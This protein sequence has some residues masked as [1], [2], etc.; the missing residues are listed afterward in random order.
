[1]SRQVV[2]R[3]AIYLYLESIIAMSV[4]YFLWFI[5]SKIA[6]LEV[7]GVSSTVISLTIIFTT[8]VDL[9]VSYGS[10]RFLGRSFS[11]GQIEDTKVLIRASLFLLCVAIVACSSAVLIFKH[12]IFPS[13]IGFDLILVS[14]LI[15]GVSSVYAM[16]RSVLIASLQTQSFPKISIISSICNISLTI[17]LVLL[18]AGAIGITLGY[19]SGFVLGTILLSCTLLGILKPSQKESKISLSLACRNI[20]GASIPSWVP[21][22]MSVVG[23]RLGTVVVFGTEGASQAGS[24]FIATSVFYAITAVMDAL[25]SVAFPI[26]SAMDDQRKRFVWRL[27]KMI[28]ITTLPISSAAILYSDEIMAIFGP[29][30][31]QASLPL[32][33]I[34][35]STVTYTFN[36]GITIL[37]Y[38]YGNY[39]QVLAIGISSSS[40]RIVLYF[41]LVPLYG[42]IGAAIAFTTGSIIAFIVSA[43]VTKKIGMKIFWKELA[44]LFAIPNTAALLLGF[45]HVEYIIGIP[46]IFT[47]SLILFLTLRLLTKSDLYDS[48]AILPDRIAKPLI[49]ILN[50]F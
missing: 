25:N 37:I 41:I 3:K 26:L 23:A 40:S 8:V 11:E 46:V 28:L 30:Y 5:L 1:V 32:K 9:G 33:I 20:L 24:Y 47:A 31:V 35:L 6:S 50:K 15:L 14:V 42:T 49:N 45:F 27:M 44:L 39:L 12:L 36:A 48:V 10:T 34:L 4:G 16:L 7:I 2:G 43:L 17:L 19:L 13:T 21:K 29:G 18:G 22:V 38:S